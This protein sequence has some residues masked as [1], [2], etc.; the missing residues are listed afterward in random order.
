[1]LHPHKTFLRLALALF[2]IFP[3][4][5]FGQVS[6]LTY[7]STDPADGGWAGY[8]YC[9]S[10]GYIRKA[11]NYCG[12]SAS[13]AFTSNMNSADIYFLGI[14]STGVGRTTN[15]PFSGGN[16]LTFTESD[17]GTLNTMASFRIWAASGATYDIDL[18][19]VTIYHEA[20]TDIDFTIQGSTTVSGTE[21][22]RTTV[23]I[24]SGVATPVSLSGNYGFTYVH[25][26]PASY[27]NFGVSSFVFSDTPLPVEWL[28]FS[29]QPQDGTVHLT[30]ATASETNSDYY[31]VQRKSEDGEW[32]SLADLPAA[33]NSTEMKEYAFTDYLAP[34]GRSQYRIRQVDIDGKMHYSKTEEILFQPAFQ[35]MPNPSSDWVRLSGVSGPVS[36]Q[37]LDLQGSVIRS[38]DQAEAS[39]WVGDLPTGIYFLRLEGSGLQVEKLVKY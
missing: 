38:F 31:V 19:S 20:G 8:T 35:I 10:N 25:V 23:T 9:T 36:G 1:M 21:L 12:Q 32:M 2:F 15:Y 18:A 22:G 5:A 14:K 24:P 3:L 17:G 37:L 11:N 7:T 4:L 30:W 39:L 6:T 34:S 28:D 27:I 13:P 26:I 29:A 33:G 16:F